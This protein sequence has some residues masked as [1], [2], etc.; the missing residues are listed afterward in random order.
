VYPVPSARC[1]SLI[2]RIGTGTPFYVG[3]SDLVVTGAGELY[4]GIND[5]TLS[6]NSG[7]LTVNIKIGAL[8]PPP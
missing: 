8:P 4:L 6:G 7:A 2:A 1:W 3:T 5:D